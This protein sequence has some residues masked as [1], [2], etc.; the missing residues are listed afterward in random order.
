MNI[1]KLSS[2]I[3]HQKVQVR[4]N[5]R[6]VLFI[7]TKKRVKNFDI[8]YEFIAGSTLVILMLTYNQL[9]L[10]GIKMVLTILT[11]NFLV[12]CTK[13]KYWMLH[14]AILLDN[15]E[16]K[17]QYNRRFPY[18]NKIIKYR[19][20]E[21]KKKMK[22][23]EDDENPSKYIGYN[24]SFKKKWTDEN[25]YLFHLQEE[26]NFNVEKFVEDFMNLKNVDIKDYGFK[27]EKSL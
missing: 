24:Y 25:Y 18:K 12:F 9:E 14:K 4:Q 7:L 1:E 27:N 19:N 11:V 10:F 16:Q 6:Y 23:I 20:L 22:I 8:T 3:E 2:T 17:V 5:E 21:F 26:Y 13:I 15:V